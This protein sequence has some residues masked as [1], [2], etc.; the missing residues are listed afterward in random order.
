MIEFDGTLTLS[1][2]VTDRARSTGWYE[3]HLGF[4]KAF[5]ADEI[6]WSE[7]NTSVAGVTIGFGDAMHVE[8]G[9]CV[10]VFGVRDIAAARTSL[11]GAGV[12]FT[13]PTLVHDGMVKL[14]TFAD[15]DGNLLM[16]AE[17]LAGD[18]G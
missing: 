9:N 4:T 8:R 15:P 16:L 17:N 11:E 1:M 2:S 5:D 18:Q 13:G 3:R 14:A 12:A 7:M 6:G 10:P